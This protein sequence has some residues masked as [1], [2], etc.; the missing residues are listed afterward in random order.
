M[1]VLVAGWVFYALRDRVRWLLP[2]LDDE[3]PRGFWRQ[4][5][6]WAVVYYLTIFC[7]L[8]GDQR[9]YLPIFPLLILPAVHRLAERDGKRCAGWLFLFLRQRC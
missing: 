8:P 3:G 2:P 9:Y 5:L 6:P 4:H 7:F 1:A